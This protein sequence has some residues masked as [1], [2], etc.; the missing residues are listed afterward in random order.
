MRSVLDCTRSELLRLRKWPA[1]WVVLG[2]WTFLGLLFGYAF[3]YIGYKTGSGP[4]IG[5]GSRAQLLAETLPHNVPSVL[6]QGMPMFGAALAMVLG[7]LAA[8][9]GFGWGTWKTTF[10]QGPSRGTVIGGSLLAVSTFVIG[11]VVFTLALFLAV[12]TGIAAIEGQSMA[13]PAISEVAKSFG[14]GLLVLEMWSLIGYTVGTIAKGPSLAIGLGLVWVLVIENL[15]RGVA[16]LLS[17]IDQLT[18]VLPG[19]AGGSLVG[20]I[21]GGPNNTPGVVR[22]VGG[23]RALVTVA[24]YVVAVA[25]L[26]F[27]VVRRRDVA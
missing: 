19:T 27:T 3:N 10:T 16:N 2:A 20:A 6:V 13:W 14:G 1:V 17:A 5:D 18:Q 21:I 9:N 24:I 23:E 7:A 8:G 22:V 25:C 12:S 26:V 4:S 11:L 15:L